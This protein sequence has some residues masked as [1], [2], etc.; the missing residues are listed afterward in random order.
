MPDSEEPDYQVMASLK[1][2]IVLGCDAEGDSFVA[3]QFADGEQYKMA[4][5]LYLLVSGAMIEET[6]K[7]LRLACESEDEAKRILQMLAGLMQQ[8]VQ[9]SAV[10]TPTTGPVVAPT[11]VF[12]R[13]DRDDYKG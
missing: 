6:V 3:V 5:L 10:Q 11:E 4:E 13:R 2:Y 9:Q 7:S 1:A 8:H 12:S